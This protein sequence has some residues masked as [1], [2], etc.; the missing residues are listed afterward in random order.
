MK[1]QDPLPP[2]LIRVVQRWCDAKN[3]EVLLGDLHEMYELRSIEK[4]STA[5]IYSWFDFLS[6]LFNGVLKPSFFTYFNFMILRNYLT[7]ATRALIKQRVHSSINI[8]GLSV[9]L[10]ISLLI[11]LFVVNDL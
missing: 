2:L 1:Q 8:I 7:V 5:R 9:G 3:A 6:L 11:T 10:S 4:L